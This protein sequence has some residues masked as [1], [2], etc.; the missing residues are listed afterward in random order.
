MHLSRVLLLH[1]LISSDQS[2]P[3]LL[4]DQLL[5]LFIG[6]TDPVVKISTPENVVM[7]SQQTTLTLQ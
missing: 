1:H 3:I 6:Q 7:R 5:H 2:V 4:F